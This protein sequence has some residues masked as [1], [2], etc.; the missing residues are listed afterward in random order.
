M[1]KQINKQGDSRNK[2]HRQSDNKEPGRENSWFNSENRE[3]RVTADLYTVYSILAFTSHSILYIV[4]P[5][6]FTWSNHEG[7]ISMVHT[8]IDLSDKLW[9]VHTDMQTAVKQGVA[10]NVLLHSKTFCPV[11]HQFASLRNRTICLIFLMRS[12]CV[13]SVCVSRLDGIKY[14]AVVLNNLVV[15][16][17]LSRGHLKYPSDFLVMWWYRWRLLPSLRKAETESCCHWLINNGSCLSFSL[18]CLPSF[19]WH[20]PPPPHTH[21]LFPF[22]FLLLTQP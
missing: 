2:R 9:V 3:N 13:R 11:L 8:D 22:E 15:L 16:T 18:V 1:T 5:S 10:H 6:P 4:K 20:A 19:L 17:F 12:P 7:L 21:L 14:C